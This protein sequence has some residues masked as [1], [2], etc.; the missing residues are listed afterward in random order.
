MSSSDKSG[1]RLDPHALLV[2]VQNS[3]AALESGVRTL[4][5]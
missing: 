4:K 5:N 1:E 2:G 3:P